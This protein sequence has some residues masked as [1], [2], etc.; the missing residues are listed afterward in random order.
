MV[1]VL[2]ILEEVLSEETANDLFP[3]GQEE[4]RVIRR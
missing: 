2:I 3:R 1:L 4:S